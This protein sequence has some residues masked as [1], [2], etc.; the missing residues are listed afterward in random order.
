MKVVIQGFDKK[1]G[2]GKRLAEEWLGC[3]Y[4]NDKYTIYLFVRLLQLVDPVLRIER[5]MLK[6]A[7]PKGL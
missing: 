6:V 5:G 4:T 2:L 3:R 1:S 7:C